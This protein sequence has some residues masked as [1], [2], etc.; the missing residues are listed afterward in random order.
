MRAAVLVMLW[1]VPGM[2]TWLRIVLTV[3]TVLAAI[4]ITPRKGAAN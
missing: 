3:W 2:P 4:E 1:M